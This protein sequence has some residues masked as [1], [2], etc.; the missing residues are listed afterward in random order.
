MESHP[1]PLRGRV[2]VEVPPQLRKSYSDVNSVAGGSS[3]S[4]VSICPIAGKARSPMR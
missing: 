2:R 1:L 3:W 4:L